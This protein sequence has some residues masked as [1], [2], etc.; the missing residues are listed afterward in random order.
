MKILFIGNSFSQDATRYIQDISRGELFV[1]NL[2]IG[3]CSLAMHAENIKENRASYDFET[4]AVA[5]RKISIKEAL[6]LERWDV[7]SIQQVSGDSGRIDTYEPYMGYVVNYLRENA[8]DARLVFHRT[9]SYEAGSTHPHF[10]LYGSDRDKM[11]AAIV[12]AST[13]MADKYGLEIIPSGDAV[14]A[15]RK[16]PDFDVTRGGVSLHRDGFHLSLDYGRY[17]AG[18]VLYRFFTGKRA[19]TVKYIPENSVPSV[20]EILRKTA[21][22]VFGDN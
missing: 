19:E 13:A 1:R 18:L 4:D 10:P 8:P 17:L 20:C 3:G 9:W 12:E 5:T 15:A 21:D 6:S 22:K 16:I 7:I 11:F 14:Q 2:Y